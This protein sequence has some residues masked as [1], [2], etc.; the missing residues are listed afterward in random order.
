MKV[1]RKDKRIRCRRCYHSFWQ[2]ASL[3]KK[4]YQCPRCNSSEVD[5]VKE[6]GKPVIEMREYDLSTPTKA[7]EG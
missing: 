4:F 3:P 5:I 7:G 1:M 2:D 6:Y